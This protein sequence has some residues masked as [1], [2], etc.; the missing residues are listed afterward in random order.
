MC[1]MLGK[2]QK[3]ERPTIVVICVTPYEEKYPKVT[4]LTNWTAR[5]I[6]VVVLL[7]S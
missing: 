5:V 4:Y 3:A 6:L 7:D 2:G 1:S